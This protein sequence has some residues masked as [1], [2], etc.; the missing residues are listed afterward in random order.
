MDNGGTAIITLEVVDNLDKE[1]PNFNR[2]LEYFG[3]SVSNGLVVDL[4][5]YAQSPFFILPNVVSGNVTTGVAGRKNVWMP[6]AKALIYDEESKDV[7]Y[8]AFFISSKNSFNKNDLVNADNFNKGE[9]D[10]DGPFNVGVTATKNG[11]GKAYIVGSPFVFSDTVDGATANASATIFMN[12]IKNSVTEDTSYSAVV[13][14]RTMDSEPLVINSMAGIIIFLLL[15][16]VVPLALV[17]TGVVI[18]IVRRKK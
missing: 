7:M 14:A 6:Y 4:V 2:I 12:M 3:V 1:M 13:P 15:L 10:E 9:N 18:W 8:D 17:V 5:N 11:K 16:F